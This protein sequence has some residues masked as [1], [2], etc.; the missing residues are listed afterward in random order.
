MLTSF[1]VVNQWILIDTPPKKFTGYCQC[2]W[3]SS[4]TW[5]KPLLVKTSHSLVLEWRE[6]KLERTWKLQP[7]WIAFI[8]CVTLAE[9]RIITNHLWLL[10]DNMHTENT[11]QLLVV[12]HAFNP[13]TW[14]AEAGGFLS[15]RPVWSTKWVQDSQGYTEKP[16]LEKPK[17]NQTKTKTKE[18]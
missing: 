9:R 7:Y 11:S 4:R 14:E 17:P 16:C 12:A 2:S 18:S 6:F 13:S 15:L 10:G 8:W 3:L 1:E 5:R